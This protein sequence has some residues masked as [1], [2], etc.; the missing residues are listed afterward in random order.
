MC[1]CIHTRACVRT[2]VCACMCAGVCMC[3]CVSV[4]VCVYVCMCVSVCM[5]D[6]GCSG[7]CPRFPPS[8]SRPGGRGQDRS[9]P[10]P[11]KLHPSAGVILAGVRGHSITRAGL[12]Y[13]SNQQHGQGEW[14]N[15]RL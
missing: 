14:T 6:N 12:D 1:M 4:C 8:F 13:T 11:P 10:P 7:V 15:S 9:L 5:C 3:V 2:C